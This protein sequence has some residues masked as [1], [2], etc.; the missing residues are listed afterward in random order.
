M[1]RTNRALLLAPGPGH[2]GPYLRSADVFHCPGDRSTTNIFGRRGPL[3][4]RSYSMNQYI[5]HGDGVGHTGNSDIPETE[6]WTY[7]PTAFLRMGDFNRTSPAQIFVFMDEHEAT[8]D[9]GIFQV[10]W[11]DTHPWVWAQFPAGRHG[12]VGALTFADGHAELRRWKDP[13][14]TPPARNLTEFNQAPRV[15]PNNPDFRWLWERMNGPY[16]FPGWPP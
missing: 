2:L 5:V 3:R 13:R 7:T 1:D 6:V 16:P 12:R 10:S 15:T 4:V 8:I 9:L 14:T 11:H